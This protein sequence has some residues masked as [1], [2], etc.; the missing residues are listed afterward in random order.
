MNSGKQLNRRQA[1]VA[2]G[3][4]GVGG[5]GE[6]KALALDGDPAQGQAPKDNPTDSV[7]ARAVERNDTAVSQL[8]T[9]QVTDRSSPWPGSIPDRFGLHGAGAAGGAIETFTAS[10]LHP[11]SKYHGD[12]ALMERI[13]LAAAFLERSQSPEGNVDLPTTNFNSPPDTAFVTNNVATAAAVAQRH[14]MPEVTA[15]VRP[16]LLKAGNALASGGIHTPNHRWVVSSA[17]AQINELF[18]NSSYT[19]RIEEW[20]G[21][22]VD[23]DSD[24]Q[25][26][27]QSTLVYDCICDR[28]FVV[29]A[30]KLNRPELVEPARENLRMLPYLLHA[31]GEVVTEISH[32]QDQ[33]ARGDAGAYWFPL[34]YLAQHDGDKDFATLASGLAPKHAYLSAF[35]EYPELLR[36]L[37]PATLLPEDYE[38]YFPVS[39]IARI[40]RL[41]L[42]GT[43]V[44]RGSS[45]VFSMQ[46]GDAAITAVR[47]ATSFFGKGQFI[48]SGFEKRGKDWFLRQSLD[49][50]YYQPVERQVT[51][52]NWEA[53]RRERRQTQVGKLEQSLE[54][55]ESKNGFRL[56]V[57]A[58][59]TAN[60]P[61]AIEIGFR[62]GGQLEGC[63]PAASSANAA[64]M[65]APS[66]PGLLLAKGTGV[67]RAGKHSIRFGPGAAPHQYTQL[68]G[69]EPS[70]PGQSVYITGFTPFDHT[71]T[72][73][74]GL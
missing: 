37:G 3:A 46:Y 31:N 35:L 63:E 68:R 21:E 50:S 43:I 24:G 44:L 20:L 1:I 67:Y 36:P 15:L 51:R 74:G 62:E 45:R 17:L 41:D 7:V 70:L 19:R 54:I 65:L 13:Q 27:E 11:Q 4:I 29:L 60:V 55:A 30:A 26:S 58:S 69:A 71:I 33:F 16:F 5:A 34:A 40:R 9:A 52:D 61:V 38:K 53:A 18:P 64:D 47:F 12:A 14:G 10:L 23:I 48:P 2:L 22:T 56:R 32:R 6:S 49:G 59:G 39:G 28:A 57:R 25:F 8:L 73:E 42:S 72:L 66:K